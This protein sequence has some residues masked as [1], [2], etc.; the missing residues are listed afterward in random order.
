MDLTQVKKDSY[1]DLSRLLAVLK[2]NPSFP[3]ASLNSRIS[4]L[5]FCSRL[6][7][8][9][10]LNDFPVKLAT[11]L[12]DILKLDYEDVA[13]VALRLFIDMHKKLGPS[14]DDTV[15]PYLDIVKDMFLNL[16]ATI[17]E[18]FDS[19]TSASIQ[20][21]SSAQSLVPISPSTN[22]EE[23]TSNTTKTAIRASSS[24]KV[25]SECPMI[26]LHL[27]SLHKRQS[28][29]QFQ[30][31]IPVCIEAMGL[32]P[33]GQTR[34]HE[35]AAAQGTFFVGVSPYI[36]PR[37][38]SQYIDLKTLQSKTMSFISHLHKTAPEFIRPYA[39]TL[40][41]AIVSLF[42]DCPPECN[43]LKRDI[44]Q[45]ARSFWGSDL[46]RYFLPYIDELLNEDVLVGPGLTCKDSLRLGAHHMF[47]DVV[48]HLR[49]D[50]NPKQID[51]IVTLYT[52]IGHDPQFT[53]S[54]QSMAFK[55][56]TNMV[57]VSTKQEPAFARSFLFRNIDAFVQKLF[58]LSDFLPFMIRYYY[59]RKLYVSQ[60]TNMASPA[61]NNEFEGYLDIGFVQPIQNS[62]KI[63][64]AS[65]D[66]L[67][68]FRAMFKLLLSNIKGT[69]AA[70]AAV[71][72]STETT[73]N[74][75]NRFV[76]NLDQNEIQLFVKLLRYAL[77]CFDVF[78]IESYSMDGTR[79]ETVDRVQPKEEKEI[80]D[81]FGSL[82]IHIEPHVF[83]EVFTSQLPYF[84]EEI[85]VNP[86]LLSVINYF[87]MS[88]TLTASFCG[89]LL[90]AL[91]DLMDKLSDEGKVSNT[92]LK[93]FKLLFISVQHF[94][95]ENEL[96]IRPQLTHILM[97]CM[98]KS[99]K[100]KHPENYF[101]V[102]RYMFRHIG[103]GRFESLHVEIQTLLPLIL[104]SLN[105]LLDSTKDQTSRDLYIEL[106][107][108][109]PVR[110]THLIPSLSSLMKPVNL[111]LQSSNPDIVGH[112]L[113]TLE[114]CIDN[115][116]QDYLEPIINPV[117]KELMDGLFLHLQPKPYNS[118]H[119]TQAATIIGKLGGRNRRFLKDPQKLNYKLNSEVGV[120]IGLYL[121]SSTKAQ[122]EFVNL[123][124]VVEHSCKI[125]RRCLQ[126]AKTD[127]SNS[128]LG[129]VSSLGGANL[130]TES[131]KTKKPMN[132]YEMYK[133][134]A[135]NVLKSVIPILIDVDCGTAEIAREFKEYVNNFLSVLEKER[136]L[137][138]R[139][140]N[141][142]EISPFCD[143]IPVSR[144]KKEAH[145]NSLVKVIVALFD[146]GCIPEI[147]DEAN[148]MI[149]HLVRHFAILA[150]KDWIETRDKIK[151]TTIVVP[152]INT[153]NSGSAINPTAAVAKIVVKPHEYLA[154]VPS[155]FGFIKGLVSVITSSSTTQRD[156]GKQ[157]LLLF[158]STCKLILG[159]NNS[160]YIFEFPVFHIL[161]A[162]FCSS[163]YK[164]EQYE[165]E[166]GVFG[167]NIIANELEMSESWVIDHELEF[168][169]ALIHVIEEISMEGTGENVEFVRKVFFSVIRRCNRRVEIPEPTTDKDSEMA[170]AEGG[171]TIAMPNPMSVIPIAPERQLKFM[172][173]ISFLISELSNCN[174]HVRESIQMAFKILS[175]ILNVEITQL[176]LSAKDRLLQPIFTKPLRAL[177]LQ[178]QI[179]HIDAIR[180]C[181]ELNPPLIDMNE[182]LIRLMSE[183]LALVDAEDQALIGK[184]AR[185]RDAV[186][187]VNLRVVCIKLLSSAMVCF[188][189][190]LLTPKH[191]STR[192]RIIS[193]FF[194]TL[195]AKN[196][197]IVDV[198]NRG[199]QLV[200]AIQQKLPK[201]LLQ[202]GLRP[203][204]VNLSDHKRLTVQGLDGLARLL[205]LLTNYFKTEIGRK[206]LDHLRAWSDPA[207][208][209]NAAGKPLSEIEDIKIV[210][211]ILDVFFLLPPAASC[212]LEDLVR[213]V[214]R[215]EAALK[216]SLSSP[217]RVPLARFLNRYS[218]EAVNFFLDK[219]ALKSPDGTDI[220]AKRLFIDMLKFKSMA[221]VRLETMRRIE[222]LVQVTFEIGTVEGESEGIE[223]IKELAV[224]DST[225]LPDNQV[226]LG[227]VRD[228]W[229]KRLSAKP[230]ETHNNRE[231][232]NILEIFIMYCRV[233]HYDTETLFDILKGFSHP[234]IYEHGFLKKFIYDDVAMTYESEC[235]RLIISKFVE[236]LH[237]LSVAQSFKATLLKMLL[238]P[239]MYISFE[240]G[241]ADFVDVK[242]IEMLHAK[243]WHPL[244]Q[245]N[246]DTIV[247][248]DFLRME[249]IQLT[250]LLV[251]HASNTV[252]VARKDVIKYAWHNLKYDDIICKQAAYVLL[253]RF[254]HAFDTPAKIVNQIF[255]HLLK[256]QQQEVRILV[257]LALD[258]LLPALPIR[259]QQPV[260]SSGAPSS[261]YWIR[262][263]KRILTEEGQNSVMQIVTIY[264][265]MIKH[266]DL[267]YESRDQFVA[268]II[269][270]LVKFGL[271]QNALMDTKVLVLD[272]IE[273][274]H[275]WE[276]RRIRESN[277][278]DDASVNEYTPTTTDRE[279][280]VEFLIR[281]SCQTT[282]NPS[283]RTSLGTRS[284]ELV[285]KL[286]TIW[287]DTAI[288]FNA[289]E[290][291]STCE[292]T[293][294]KEILNVVE[295]AINIL[296]EILVLK[297]PEWILLHLG[298]IQK[299]I[300]KWVQAS[301]D[302]ITKALSPLIECIYEAIS[303]VSNKPTL[304]PSESFMSLD[305]PQNVTG[306]VSTS[307]STS[308][309]PEV[310]SF[311]DMIDGVIRSGFN[312]NSK[313]VAVVLLLKA[314]L[315]H[316]PDALS[317][318][319]SS[320]MALLQD[321][322]KKAIP[323][324]ETS[325]AQTPNIGI[326]NSTPSTPA[327]GIVGGTAA[328]QNP[329]SEQK[330][331]SVSNLCAILL[332]LVC[333]LVKLGDSRLI[334]LQVLSQLIEKSQDNELL[335]TILDIVK[336]WVIN[337][338]ESLPTVKEKAN[339]LL[340]MM[341]F[342]KLQ[343]QT[344]MEK[345]LEL[346]ADIYSDPVF[347][348]SEYTV[349]LEPSF[350]AGTAHKNSKLR[351]RFTKL[352][353][354]SIGMSMAYRLNYVIGVQN[355]AHLAS[356]F[357]LNQALDLIMGSVSTHERIHEN[358]PFYRTS[359]FVSIKNSNANMDVDEPGDEVV[360]LISNHRQ[361]LFNLQKLN[362]SE[363]IEPIRRLFYSD[364]KFTYSMW[365]EVYPLCWKL[366]TPDEHH[367][368]INKSFI[369]F[370]EKEYHK[371]Q[372]GMRPN[373]IQALLE[374][375]ARCTPVVKLPPQLVRNLGKTFNAWYIAI[376]LLQNAEST[377][378]NKT[379]GKIGTV[380]TNSKEEE[381][382]REMTLDYLAE[383]YEA[384]D[385]SDYF[386]GLWRRR[387]LFAETNAAISYEQAGMWSNA[388]LMYESAQEKAR[389]TVLPFSDSEYTLWETN[390]IKCAE[391]LNQW[392]LLTDLAK[393]T[394]DTNLRLESGWRISDWSVEQDQF[395][396]S[397]NSLGDVPTSRRK[398]FEAYLAL[399]SADTNGVDS[400]C[401]D[402]ID[403]GIQLTLSKWVTLPEY[404]GNAHIPLLHQFQLFVELDEAE[405]I[406]KNLIG[407][408][409]TNLDQKAA[410]LKSHLT[411]WRDRLPNLWD[412]I[413]LWS[414][415]VAW[416]Q[417]IFTLIN[418][419]YLPLMPPLPTAGNSPS[420]S[421]AN[422]GHHETAWII[423]RFAQVARKH[424]L[425]NVAV[426]LLAAI[427]KLPNIEIHEAFFKLREQAKCHFHNPSEYTSGLD[428][429]NN[430][431]LIYFNAQQKAEF[432]T[433]KGIFLSKLNYHDVAKSAFSEAVK[434]DMNLPNAW[435]S[436]GQY[437]DRMF[438]ESPQTIAN[439]VEAM[440]C[441]LNAAAQYN[442]FKARKFLIRILWLLGM[443]DDKQSITRAFESYNNEFP[444]WYWIAL[445]PQLL[446]SLSY[447]EGGTSKIILMKL[448]KS[449]P[450]ALHFQLRT[451]KEEL[452]PLKRTAQIALQKSAS[453]LAQVAQSSPG[454]PKVTPSPAPTP[455]VKA[456][457]S[458][459]ND[460]DKPA[461]K[462]EDNP[463]GDAN[464]AS[465][466]GTNM[467]NGSTPQ[468]AKPKKYAWDYVEEIMGLL[469]TAFPLLALSMEAMSEQIL[470]KLK[471]TTDEDVYRLIVALLND[472]FTQLAKNP[473]DAGQLSA[474]TEQNLIRFADGMVPNHL[475]YK[476]AFERDFI[477]SKPD[478]P[479]L[480]EKFREW[481]D[482]LEVLL[483]SKPQRQN[484]ENFS[485]YLVE[486]EH[487]KFDEI[488]VP[489]QYLLMK[490]SN[491]D[492]IRIDRYMPEIDIVRAH[493]ICHRR[494]T[495]KGHDGSLHPFIIQHPAG[496]YCRREERILQL[497]RIL[498][499]TL[500]NKKESRRRNLVFHLPTIIPL[501][502]AVRLV[503]DDITYKS[504]QEIYEDYCRSQGIHKEDP[505][506]Y[507]LSRMKEIVMSD[508]MKRGGKIDLPNLKTE[509]LSSI[510]ENI[511]P[512][513]ILT[514]FMKKTMAS[515]SDLW[516]IRKHFT[517]QLAAVTFMTYILCVGQRYPARFHI[518]CQTGNIWS[519]ELVPTWSGQLISNKEYVPFRLTPNFQHFLTNTGIEGPFASSLMA[520]GRCLTEPELDLDQY[521]CIF[522]RDE[523]VAWQI[524]NSRPQPILDHSNFKDAVSQNVEL[525]IK[526]AQ[527]LSCRAEREKVSENST[528]PVNQTIL[529][530]ISTAVNPLKLA[531]MDVP[532]LACL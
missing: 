231:A 452:A 254:V 362:I 215:L 285:S 230:I 443:D 475:K 395:K 438:K 440:T 482:K 449:F 240:N 124:N 329:P 53:M 463:G 419:S 319:M 444:N 128:K 437:A 328:I 352:L 295:H 435:G 189:D 125:L 45:S 343:D 252:E 130:G 364:T 168:V 502:L 152:Q 415:L 149:E 485:H 174:S 180:Y 271:A 205:E 237:D 56:L 57:E 72:V 525:I 60:K 509:I 274:L 30:A 146:A 90:R 220:A 474:Q 423:N 131:S 81:L 78:N 29:P 135:F 250:T 404:V 195:Y 353:D 523:L 158:H 433:L 214:I 67:K 357:W 122:R 422:R 235:K 459:A 484:L 403:E 434:T 269:S 216:R 63:F 95:K 20:S 277:A 153:A 315:V 332:K 510:T 141:V 33:A 268:P 233:E 136:R 460:S 479:K 266:A 123:D 345:Y 42:K 99:Q 391:K 472:G 480:V 346:V 528:I 70:L 22:S 376:E 527:S 166:G 97:S 453:E 305:E 68:E 187:L 358:S 506:V 350:L 47:V 71:P 210:V 201:D 38:R 192:A 93:L 512:P 520:I 360:E 19:D 483:D 505:I 229:R 504:L 406:R 150:V 94:P 309:P 441:Y 59:R 177:P 118:V 383:M 75:N 313:P 374:G 181:L 519:S 66:I 431:N 25:L 462:S 225:W 488:E 102:M 219:F 55:L 91:I 302:R 367:H 331:E 477:K 521:L 417:H 384:L 276:L 327:L 203:I 211:G 293:E 279:T 388:Q 339:L 196:P 270:I 333:P 466:S 498:N 424:Q 236:I 112:G 7:F 508:E 481:R 386:Y 223:I 17:A 454:T 103:S 380:A 359:S 147:C 298:D 76:R 172:S 24:F 402:I 245:D 218:T 175:E 204:L 88:Q 116:V 414:D 226:V 524:Q 83:Q 316:R 284:V 256:V 469:K 206:L 497:F 84:L 115:L 335:L 202:A 163:C 381:K 455:T 23:S 159:H 351:E 2:Q 170:D 11:T 37:L 325:V 186:T 503:Q 98:R 428:V 461:A 154:G 173:L 222:K 370:L 39:E 379:T 476:A 273:L 185:Q 312:E 110:L 473:T 478:L 43:N 511:I 161:A 303:T 74:A 409:H 283:T 9:L 492:F 385:E 439:G 408:N 48:H 247:S 140:K 450:Q 465:A 148:E 18:L 324:G 405:K 198:A 111:A 394:H 77:K 232:I 347:A 429:V 308:L 294:A 14:L 107:L 86:A 156:L 164:Q 139:I 393:N 348:I 119:A 275:T 35:E 213:E 368:T 212:F 65:P 471:P 361:F 297:G 51:Q 467:T 44:L 518:S 458:S 310:K 448:A 416:R 399:L 421:V 425:S 26:V 387:S 52:K 495:I 490:D 96:I 397:L 282:D 15:I 238:I 248:D 529:D 500:E 436:W 317:A 176:L 12:L 79:L 445:I 330:I 126:K 162:Q 365:V 21:P 291:V 326:L 243:I 129:L 28:I 41:K 396:Q 100:A 89:L 169:K 349:R 258:I 106:C 457:D 382:I 16:N 61:V 34:M 32:Q 371:K 117:I 342:E 516:M 456:E 300:T 514:Q 442:N 392:E 104:E 224:Q 194:K 413:V 184:T 120:E 49:T 143:P 171:A 251:Q 217:F 105:Y 389:S 234:D 375:I 296:R 400:K 5:D 432:W 227:Y 101:Q 114:L 27:Q 6:N 486:F 127:T 272:L 373:V 493:G 356:Y 530:L 318:C 363:L 209:E 259:T 531:Q 58:S 134:D 526:R 199:L 151:N 239:V 532:F 304:R 8:A 307:S 31:L 401:R 494:I 338:T 426:T 132:E 278:M 69:L 341:A 290:K 261:P 288:R 207:T 314:A 451:S 182:E 487:Q 193:V 499:G 378:I 489:G 241:T 87:L 160:D 355:W 344:L 430:T 501:A 4:I 244:L 322:A 337:K 513:T 301:N 369:P 62:G 200:L 80:Y 145:E 228:V 155:T 412:D 144:T 92:L 280:F 179:G 183:A 287:P 262:W 264:Q 246:A 73:D 292:I 85:Y 334:L 323:S 299:C 491:K 522:V 221:Q 464:G 420:S 64:D 398:T 336:T 407:T 54:I 289:F 142:E 82:F 178:T 468:T 10:P 447:K 167:I 515:Y 50:F 267:F 242:L 366:L 36:S 265:C 109:I 113:R 354:Q 137:D 165:R 190:F 40:T 249:L 208:L 13:L 507:H 197:E 320:M 306:A 260:S 411:T 46:R 1:E 157:A 410:D 321:F 121:S 311:N 188:A 138:P 133:I 257:K 517:G 253:A 390:W 418:K 446:H 191:L 470:G 281:L 372:I 340:R 377:K 286:L 263:I 108:I 427:Y 255:V 496:R 3:L